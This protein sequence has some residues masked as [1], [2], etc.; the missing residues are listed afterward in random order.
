MSKF[1]H[2]PAFYY[3][4]DETPV[5]IDPNYWNWLESYDGCDRFATG[6]EESVWVIID[7]DGE[8]WETDPD[9]WAA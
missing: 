9:E 4:C 7:D 6:P 1:T 8:Y 5:V 2:I 3:D